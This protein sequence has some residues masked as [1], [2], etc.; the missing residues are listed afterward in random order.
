MALGVDISSS[1][2]THI[3]VH[4]TITPT[5]PLH[6]HPHHGI[7]IVCLQ[8][9]TEMLK[10]IEI[11]IAKTDRFLSFNYIGLRFYYEE[12]VALNYY[13]DVFL[14]VTIKK[15]KKSFKK[16]PVLIIFTVKLNLT[17]IFRYC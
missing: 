11:K 12:N 3:P 16:C 17:I 6:P 14:Q 15:I 5:S 13:F 8:A 2:P 10:N 1:S 7:V 4:H 9:G